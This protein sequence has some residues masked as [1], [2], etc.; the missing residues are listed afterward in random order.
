[1]MPQE[2]KVSHKVGGGTPSHLTLH[3]PHSV[4]R[5]I[6]RALRVRIDPGS[7]IHGPYVA[8]DDVTPAEVMIIAEILED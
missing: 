4:L 5:K 7:D 8:I 3:G 2:S 1:M 6:S